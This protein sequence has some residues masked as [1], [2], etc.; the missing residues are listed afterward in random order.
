[1]SATELATAPDTVPGPALESPGLMTVTRRGL[2]RH[3]GEAINHVQSG[4]AVRIID[5]V[6]GVLCAWLFPPD[7]EPDFY[8]QWELH[9][10]E[11]LIRERAY[12]RNQARALAMNARH[13]HDDQ[14]HD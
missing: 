10:D 7:V 2:N 11:R 6:S 14:V 13:P 12:R 9:R 1:M 8:R 5:D 4:G 3:Q